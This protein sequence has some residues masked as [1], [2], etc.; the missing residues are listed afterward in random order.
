[1][2]QRIQS[3]YFLLGALISG[4]LAFFL[5]LFAGDEGPRMLHQYPI[6]M[7]GFLI[8]AVLSIMALIS[9]KNRKNQVVYGRLAILLSFVVFGFMLYHWYEV[10]QAEASRLGTGVFLPLILVVLLSMANR[11][12]MNDEAKVQAADRFR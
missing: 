12:V 11:A 10:Y 7:A 2:I 3:I 6:F 4:G 5:S 1:M 9:F 8:I